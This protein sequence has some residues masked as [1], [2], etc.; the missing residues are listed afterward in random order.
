MTGATPPQTQPVDG[1]TFPTKA[2]GARPTYFDDDGATDAVIAI[3]T[4]L[5]AEVWALRERVGALEA[6][7]TQSGALVPGALE[8]HEPTDEQAD[9]TAAEAVAFASRVFRVFEEMR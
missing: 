1:R 5:S 7:L 4:A 8:G 3:V 6:V 9:A 2:R